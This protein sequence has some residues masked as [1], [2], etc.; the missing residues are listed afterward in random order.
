LRW[1]SERVRPGA[2]TGP[3]GGADHR[4]ENEDALASVVKPGPEFELL[5]ENALEGFTLCSPVAAHG[6][7]FLRTGTALYCIGERDERAPN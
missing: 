5:A 4:R 7:L 2:P 6:Q 3:T 1:A